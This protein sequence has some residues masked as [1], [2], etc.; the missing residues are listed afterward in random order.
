MGGLP[1]PK[2]GIDGGRRQQQAGACRQPAFQRNCWLTGRAVLS[3]QLVQHAV[4]AR[5]A[6]GWNAPSSG[7]RPGC[8]RHHRAARVLLTRLFAPTLQPHHLKMF[9]SNKYIYG[10]I[11][12]MADGHIVAAARR[13][14]P[15]FGGWAAREETL[16]PRP[17]DAMP[18][19]SAVA[20]CAGYCRWS[21]G[22]LLLPP[23]HH[24]TLP[25]STIEPALREG[26]TAA[27]TSASCS[28]AASR[29]GEVLAQRA[30]QAG[31][32]GVHWQRPHGQ[33]YHGKRKA[34]IEALRGAGLPLI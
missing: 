17:C 9:F 23:P 16:L 11:V 22:C 26:L 5:Q 3:I 18:G 12:R 7:S 24:P 25:C 6:L 29:V 32:A 31:L 34:L 19:T 33:R 15:G 4:Y 10:Q 13:V 27:G 20:A 8:C 30:Q 2:V 1:T 14:H 21:C 28:A